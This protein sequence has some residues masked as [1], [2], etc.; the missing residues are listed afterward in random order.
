MVERSTI[1]TRRKRTKNFQ[2][3]LFQDR[4]EKLLCGTEFLR[5][6]RKQLKCGL[7]GPKFNHC[8]T[9]EMAELIFYIICSV[10]HIGD[11]GKSRYS[12]DQLKYKVKN[13][14]NK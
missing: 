6:C 2:S 9:R 5:G 8:F 1:R 10:S 14:L 3:R 4:K 7:E 12:E 11:Q 13:K